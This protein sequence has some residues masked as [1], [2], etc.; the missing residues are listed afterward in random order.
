MSSLFVMNVQEANTF[1]TTD[2]F[3]VMWMDMEMDKTS[4][5]LEEPEVYTWVDKA[6]K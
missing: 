4:N 5:T 3:T 2:I 1:Q 6:L